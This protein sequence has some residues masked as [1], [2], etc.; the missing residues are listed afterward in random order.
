V[1]KFGAASQFGI[2]GDSWL[3]TT[4]GPAA[5]PGG[6]RRKLIVF[7]VVIYGCLIDLTVFLG[8]QI[9]ATCRA[10]RVLVP[11][12]PLYVTETVMLVGLG[13][14]CAFAIFM[15]PRTPLLLDRL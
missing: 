10:A 4:S 6:R 9:D 7:R 5:V 3:K 12:D 15:L 11:S 8:S 1:K 14:F 2:K 13:M